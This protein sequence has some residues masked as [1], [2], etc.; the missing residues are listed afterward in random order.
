[1]KEQ[2]SLANSRITEI[3]QLS[4]KD[5]IKLYFSR[6]LVPY[7]DLFI[8]RRARLCLSLHGHPLSGYI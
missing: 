2:L 3:E 8:E 6:N 1:M 7:F 4:I 5:V